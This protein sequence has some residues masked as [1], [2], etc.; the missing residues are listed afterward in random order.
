MVVSSNPFI[1]EM[2]MNKLTKVLEHLANH[3]QEAARELM[4][5]YMVETSRAIWP[6]IMEAATAD[7]L[8]DDLDDDG[9]EGSDLED[10]V[11]GVEDDLR[12]LSVHMEELR[13]EFDRLMGVEAE[14]HPELSKPL[15][16]EDEDFA[17]DADDL[18]D[19]SDDL[20]DDGD[21]ENAPVK[22]GC[23]KSKK[24]REDSD[25]FDLDALIDKSINESFDLEKA[26]VEIED[27]ME[28]GVDGHRV[29]TNRTSP[30]VPSTGPKKGRGIQ[31]PSTQHVGYDREPAPAM[32]R[33]PRLK[34]QVKNASKGQI[35]L[36]GDLVKNSSF[37]TIEKDFGKGNTVSPVAKK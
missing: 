37:G 17:D 3:D 7:E 6:K 5:E 19:D 29:K 33:N 9:S 12:D 1:L 27:A 26:K 36:K 16:D 18:T 35:P 10:R 21:D 30:I 4:H 2:P 8:S 22:E 24:V 15:S 28:V 13:A 32:E 23:G 14:E 34:N 20:S 31:N 25:D 11:S